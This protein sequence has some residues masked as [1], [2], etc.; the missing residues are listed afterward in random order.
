M[1]FEKYLDTLVSIFLLLVLYPT[2]LPNSLFIGSPFELF[3]IVH[4][5]SI[6]K[7]L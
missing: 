2:G 1:K 5:R 6:P 4:I 3:S 7:G